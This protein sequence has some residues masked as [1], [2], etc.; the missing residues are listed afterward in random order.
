MPGSGVLVIVNGQTDPSIDFA[1]MQFCLLRG[2][3]NPGAFSTRYALY[4]DRKGRPPGL[5][6]R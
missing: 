3:E 5:L 6:E 4:R 2:A 1:R